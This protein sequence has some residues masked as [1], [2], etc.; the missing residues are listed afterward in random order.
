MDGAKAKMNV[1]SEGFLRIFGGEYDRYRRANS[2]QNTGYSHTPILTLPLNG[3][4]HGAGEIMP[5]HDAIGE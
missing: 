4:I 2:R 1:E 5:C 3:R